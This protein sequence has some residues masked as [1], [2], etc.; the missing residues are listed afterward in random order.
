MARRPER[1]QPLQRSLLDRLSVD[2]AAAGRTPASIDELR[3]AVRRD[4]ERLLNTRR[5]CLT[6]PEA[7]VAL[8]PSLAGYGMPDYAGAII[9]A[10]TVGEQVRREIER[11]IRLYEPR[12]SRVKV[13][14]LGNTEPL[15][16]TLRF[17]IEAL[18][19]VQ[20]AAEPVVFSSSLEP[21]GSSFEVR[22]G[23]P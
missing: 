9:D 4:L 17:R 23:K 8:E 1:N 7:V 6:A 10:T 16:R 19:R 22:Q 2:D 15:D 18:L 14:L 11:V 13:E 5:R 12:L 21:S 20:P 3:R